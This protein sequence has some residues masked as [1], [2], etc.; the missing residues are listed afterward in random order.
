MLEDSHFQILKSYPKAT[1]IKTVWYWNKDRHT[2][3]WNGIENQEINPDIHGQLIFD[4]GA[5]A[6]Q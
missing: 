3:Q 5:K 2:D 4:K 6:I 1:L